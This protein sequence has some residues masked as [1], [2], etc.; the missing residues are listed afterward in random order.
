MRKRLRI[1]LC[2]GLVPLVAMA[3]VSLVWLIIDSAMPL[4]DYFKARHADL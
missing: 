3:I 4:E 1:M 2:Y